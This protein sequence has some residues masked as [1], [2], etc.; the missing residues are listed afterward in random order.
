[1]RS[2]SL[3]L[4]HVARTVIEAHHYGT[5]CR[6]LR[7]HAAKWPDIAKGLDFQH[8][9]IANIKADFTKMV[10]GPGSYMDEVLSMWMDWGPN[11]ARGTKDLAT[12]EQLQ[13]VIND[14]NLSKLK[15]TLE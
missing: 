5:L 1:M 12:L 8:S 13:R 2:L 3:S 6:Q 7:P 10:G 15:L 11:D 4:S 14:L 9:E